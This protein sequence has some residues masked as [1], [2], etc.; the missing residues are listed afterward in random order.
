MLPS[1]DMSVT[2][3]QAVRNAVESERASAKFYR[4]LAALDLPAEVRVFFE[5]MAVQE[6]HHAAAIQKE[7]QRLVGDDLPKDADAN[8]GAVETAPDWL[9]VE[10]ISA[11]QALQIALENEQKA[12]LYYD[13]IA[14]HCPEP[15]ARFFR[16][17][18]ETEEEHARKLD[19]LTL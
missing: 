17:L 18:S 9:V 5:E 3:Q 10:T 2:L 14:D 6:D 4:A 16:M 7:G 8:V 15:E 12:S 11:A 1:N 19:R 13:A